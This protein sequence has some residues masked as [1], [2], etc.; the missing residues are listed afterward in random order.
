MTQE[1]DTLPDLIEKH[2][3]GIQAPATVGQ[4]AE[5]YASM[6]LILESLIEAV[7]LTT[8]AEGADRRASLDIIRTKLISSGMTMSKA[9]EAIASEFEDGQK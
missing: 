2:L 1:E 4:I 7:H 5:V 3:S 9:L 8:L 6:F